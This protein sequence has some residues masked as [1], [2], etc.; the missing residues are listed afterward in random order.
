MTA[1]FRSTT[2]RWEGSRPMSERR[3]WSPSLEEARRA[4]QLLTALPREQRQVIELAFFAGLTQAEIAARVNLPLGTVK[5]RQRLALRK[6]HRALVGPP[7][8]A[9]SG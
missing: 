1:T 5:G 9:L 4:R 8:V 2:L 7:Q 6:L 3:R